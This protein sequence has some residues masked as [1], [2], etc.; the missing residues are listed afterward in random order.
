[1]R[2]E[3]WCASAFDREVDAARSEHVGAPVTIDFTRHRDKS[4]LCAVRPP[5]GAC[6]VRETL[7]HAADAWQHRGFSVGTLFLR[8]C[9]CVLRMWQ[10]HSLEPVRT[11]DVAVSIHTLRSSQTPGLRLSRH[12][13]IV[14][15]FQPCSE[16][17]S[18]S[19][20]DLTAIAH[21]NFPAVQC[22]I[23]HCNSGSSRIALL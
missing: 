23:V 12:G 4:L 6:L 10:V 2:G 9:L 1:M 17:H 3:K 7:L 15:T 8:F 14:E 5:F 11:D 18:E 22:S 13:Q 20:V 19:I 21:M 16:L